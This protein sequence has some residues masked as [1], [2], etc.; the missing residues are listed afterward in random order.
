MALRIATFEVDLTPPVGE[1]IA[2]GVN[3]KT[4]SKIFLRGVVLDDG[5]ARAVLAAADI[6]GLYGAVHARWR[7]VLARAA[8]TSARRV[9]LHCVHQH[10]SLRPPSAFLSKMLSTRRDFTQPN[11][12][13]YAGL[14]K[15]IETA[16]KRAM[17]SGWQ[18]VDSLATSERRLT[19]L[20]SNR[21]L[22]D[23][24]GKVFAMRWSMTSDPKLQRHPVGRIDPILRTIG[25][26]GSNGRILATLHFY[27][28]HPMGAYGRDMCGADIPGVALDHLRSKTR[29]H[30]IYFT[31]CA[32]DI[33][34]GK[35]TTASKEKNLRVLGRRLGEALA[36]N[37]L[38][39][40][41]CA[42]G[43]LS[44]AYE[45]FKM[46]LD[47]RRIHRAGLLARIRQADVRSKLEWPTT[48]LEA[49]NRWSYWGR[50]EIARLSIGPEVHMLSLPAE[51]VVEYQL[52]AQSLVPERFLA[53]AAYADGT[54]GYIPT[55]S[56]YS[57]GGY[58]PGAGITTPAVEAS[59]KAALERILAKLR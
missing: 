36:A 57:E 21:R 41:P 9:L 43:P 37:V 59:Y 32:G 51:T 55:A 58:E 34:F 7:N 40:M 24:R 52:F 50:P 6:I 30:H 22:L 18:R 27:A 38:S 56:M 46:P 17:R 14:L 15:K 49:V 13:F 8:G 31:G 23:K 16:V 12:A 2:F 5:R 29:G 28:T 42:T 39:L 25:F 35:Y 10:D 54:Y 1:P 33:T 26:L 19:G 47:T 53:V 48:R 20:A 4:D 11:A 45:R 44:F 3:R